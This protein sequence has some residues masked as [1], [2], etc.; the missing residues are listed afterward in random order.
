MIEAINYVSNISKQTV[1]VHSVFSLSLTTKGQLI[2]TMIQF[3]NPKGNTSERFDQ[4]IQQI[5]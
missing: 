2:L 5:Y 4:Q 1:T 3:G